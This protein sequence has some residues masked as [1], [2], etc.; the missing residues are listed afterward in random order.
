MLSSVEVA[1]AVAVVRSVYLCMYMYVVLFSSTSCNY[2]CSFPP[3]VEGTRKHNRHICL[4]E[5]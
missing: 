3:H 5:C 2:R 4:I 1:V